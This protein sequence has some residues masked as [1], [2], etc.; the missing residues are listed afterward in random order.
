MAFH[1]VTL[2]AKP[3]MHCRALQI[4]CMVLAV[5]LVLA[6]PVRAQP[7]SIESVSIVSETADSVTLQIVYSYSGD[8]GARVFLSAE[9]QRDGDRLS[10]SGYR[11]GAVRTGRHRARVVLSAL[12]RAPDL[13]TTNQIEIGMYAGNQA[14]FLERTFSFQKTWSR[15][16]AT[17]TPFGNLIAVPQISSIVG[18]SVADLSNQLTVRP[19]DPPAD[20][21]AVER[22]VQ[23]DGSIRL[24]N[25][26][27]T[28]RIRSVGKEIVINPDGTRTE[29]FQA[30]A[31]PPTPPSAPPNA[32]HAAWVE[33]ELASQLE[34]IRMLVGYDEASVDHYLAQEASV[35]PY[36]RI[37][38]RTSAIDMLVRP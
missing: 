33:A 37:T 9:M 30:N 22:R 28:V 23:A 6:E 32:T 36:Q 34:V 38:R 5:L 24:R 19:V 1:P 17:L 2:L 21:E 29:F 4:G 15:S 20:G 18:S 13:F 35:S 8:H 7:N 14:P 12:E 31:Q 25:P 3:I 11:P 10:Y 27:G 16:S 26:D